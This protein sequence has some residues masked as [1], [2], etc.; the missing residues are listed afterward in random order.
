MQALSTATLCVTA[1]FCWASTAQ[2]ATQ[3]ITLAAGRAMEF[4]VDPETLQPQLS[5]ERF[6]DGRVRK[7]VYGDYHSLHGMQEPFL[8]QTYMDEVLEDQIIV[9][10]GASN[11]GA[12]PW[13]FDVPD[14]WLSGQ[15]N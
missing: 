9:E 13:L 8:I 3:L 1:T 2:A 5:Y 12:M 15:L 11:V 4:W 7:T 14:D 6:T 10:A